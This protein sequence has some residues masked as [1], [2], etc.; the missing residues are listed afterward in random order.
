MSFSWWWFEK[1]HIDDDDGW[2]KDKLDKINPY[3]RYWIAMIFI[4]LNKTYR[5]V[6][7]E[8]TYEKYE[9]GNPAISFEILYP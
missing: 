9:I 2:K 4:E 3:R 6:R 8:G 1:N 5:P 7:F